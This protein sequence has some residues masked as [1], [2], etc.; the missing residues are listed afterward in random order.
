MN[1]WIFYD[2]QMWASNGYNMKKKDRSKSTSHNL[3]L[4]PLECFIFL[5]YNK[6]VLQ[7]SLMAV[8]FI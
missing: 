5:S 7:F 1:C 4:S 3:L 6:S 8:V 2:P